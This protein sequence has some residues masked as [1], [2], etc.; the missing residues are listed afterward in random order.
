[1]TSTTQTREDRPQLKLHHLQEERRE[2]FG[3]PVRPPFREHRLTQPDE[4][5]TRLSQ[6]LYLSNVQVL[7]NR[8]L[9]SEDFRLNA[10]GSPVGLNGCW[11]ELWC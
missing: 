7:N 4:P 10:G 2:L 3:C 5:Q 11:D 1:M 6:K 9:N 8:H